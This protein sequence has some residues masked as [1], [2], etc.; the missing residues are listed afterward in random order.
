[1][2]LLAATLTLVISTIINLFDEYAF[3][4]AAYAAVVQPEK[5]NSVL[6]YR[7]NEKASGKYTF[8]FKVGS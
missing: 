3:V 2:K 7:N 8:F 6:P 5:P 1:M 4:P